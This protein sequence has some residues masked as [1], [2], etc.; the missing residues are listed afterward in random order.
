M[1]VKNE[2]GS[3]D[4][5]TG[6]GS[7]DRETEIPWYLKLFITTVVVEQSSSDYDSKHEI[8]VMK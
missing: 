6:I 3:S 7:R 5:E 8:S 1:T 2:I 4:R